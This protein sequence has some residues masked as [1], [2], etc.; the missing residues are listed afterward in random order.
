MKTLWSASVF[1]LLMVFASPV[2]GQQ[3][4]YLT[5]VASQ[6][7]QKIYFETYSSDTE[8]WVH[9]TDSPQKAEVK[10]HIKAS[11]V[12]SDIEVVDHIDNKADWLMITKHS[13]EADKR[14][15]ISSYYNKNAR[16]IH[17]T[18]NPYGADIVICMNKDRILRDVDRSDREE[19]LNKVVAALLFTRL[20]EPQPEINDITLKKVEFVHEDLKAAG[21][22]INRIRELIAPAIVH[23]SVSHNIDRLERIIK[24]SKEVKY[25]IDSLNQ[26]IT[27]LKEE[28]D[29]HCDEVILLFNSAMSENEVVLLDLRDAERRLDM[30]IRYNDSNGVL[31]D[32]AKSLEYYDEALKRTIA[33]VSRIEDIHQVVLD[34]R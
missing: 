6:K 22:K 31:D 14:L 3:R 21:D 12:R 27:A 18:D 19:Y 5:T 33:N 10:V 2:V 29:L 24:Y 4:V 25:S 23:D 11:C 15:Y 32:L 16:E 26:L 13:T 9:F 7:S 28:L 8:N 1:L 34:C 20:F 17:I 30:A